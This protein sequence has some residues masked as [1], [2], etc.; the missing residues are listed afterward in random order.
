MFERRSLKFPIT[1]GVV[2]IVLI[3]VLIVGWVVITAFGASGSNPVLFG[4]LLAVG[5]SLLV[6]VLVGVTMYLTLSIKAINL[7]QRQSNFIDAVTHELKSPIASL[8]LYLQTLS[9]QD[10]SSTERVTFHNMMLDDVERLD[11]LINHLL[12]AARLDRQSPSVPPEEVDVDELLR[13]IAYDVADRYRQ[14]R[15]R[16]RLELEP[17]V[18]EARREDLTIVFRNLIDNAIKYAGDPP[19]VRVSLAVGDD[20]APSIQIEDNGRGIPAG[21]RR[22]IFGRF[23]RLGRE[24][25]RD[26]PGTGLG[27]YLARSLVQRLKASIR[28]RDPVS[29]QGTVFEV[30]LPAASLRGGSHRKAKPVAAPDGP[31]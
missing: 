26:R 5:T 21:L 14:P 2:L 28:I 31:S 18:V 17:C 29:G 16:V 25:E 7:S 3:V 8:K 1:L 24:L 9:R 19:S 27:L 4:T 11:Q 20:R 15:D 23:V 6:I 12:D 13:E 30:R 10:V 22:R